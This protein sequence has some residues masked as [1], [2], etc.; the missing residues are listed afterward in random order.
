MAKNAPTAP[1]SDIVDVATA[2]EILGV[3]P[4]TVRRLARD[5]TLP[6]E[7]LAGGYVFRHFV[8][9]QRK[10]GVLHA[11]AHCHQQQPAPDF[12]DA[13]GHAWHLACAREHLAGFEPPPLPES[14]QQQNV[15][16][17][18][19]GRRP[20]LKPA[21]TLVIHYSDDGPPPAELQQQQRKGESVACSLCG[22]RDP[23]PDVEDAAGR[24]WHASCAYRLLSY[25]ALAVEARSR[26]LGVTLIRGD[27]VVTTI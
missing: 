17:K 18:N 23:V 9:Q 3:H 10:T 26:G 5:G 15:A 14:D 4:E 24:H 2:A 19:G 7:Y 25:Y 22:R 12:E 6:S 27:Q 20:D 21:G 13:A 8:L 11:C 1:A 16:E